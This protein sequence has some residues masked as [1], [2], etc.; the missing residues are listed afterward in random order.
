M[1]SEAIDIIRCMQGLNRFKDWMREIQGVLQA[2][3]KDDMAGL[4]SEAFSRRERETE[5]SVAAEK[6]RCAD[7]NDSMVEGLRAG[8]LSLQK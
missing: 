7:A 6:A 3:L 8:S 5:E 2:K 1:K 4:D